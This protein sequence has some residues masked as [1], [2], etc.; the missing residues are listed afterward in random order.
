MNPA[1][2]P[3][4]DRLFDDITPVQDLA[5]EAHSSFFFARLLEDGDSRDLSWLTEREDEA[6]LR[7][8]V[9][10]RGPRLLSTRSLAFWTLILDLDSGLSGRSVAAEELWTL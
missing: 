9:E 8:W 4:F 10:N 7:S 6:R 3:S 2:P 1:P 5:I